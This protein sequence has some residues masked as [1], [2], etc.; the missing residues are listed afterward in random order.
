MKKKI[1]WGIIII[2]AAAAL[3]RIGLFVKQKLFPEVKIEEKH[4]VPVK[5]AG[6][7]IIDMTESIK[8]TG[9]IKGIEVVN[10]FSQVP[11][12]V[13]EILIKQGQK[14]FKNQTIIKINRDI[15]GMEYMPAIVES[16]ISGYVGNIMVDRGMTVQPS[17]PLAQVVNMSSVEAV[18]QIIEEDINR[19][20]TGMSAIIKVEAF[21]G[22]TFTG[23]VYKKSAVLNSVSRTQEA[24]ILISNAGL[25]L[26]H[27]MFADVEIIAGKRTNILAVPVDSVMKDEKDN[28]FV[29]TVE[30]NIAKKRNV[31]TGLTVKDFTEIKEGLSK[32]SV[33]VTLGKE[34]ISDGEY[35][36]VY[37]DDIP[38]PE[39]E[40]NKNDKGGAK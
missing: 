26:K 15:V 33:V 12:K 14:V 11:G 6:A 7:R 9:D 20:Q 16:P 32:N 40:N 28:A 35:L 34:N 2:I 19:V 38:G 22:R 1:I 23:H 21:P 39:K 29:Y 30:D 31:V 17:T 4:V 24:H 10:V 8:L 5:A 18:V 27:G 25:D 37:R 13:Q 36:K 3:F